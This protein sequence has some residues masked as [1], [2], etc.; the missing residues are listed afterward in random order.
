MI[1]ISRYIFNDSLGEQPTFVYDENGQITGYKT[2]VGADTVF[3]FSGTRE[4][5]EIYRWVSSDS[6]HNHQYTFTKD[7][8]HVLIAMGGG[9]NNAV[10]NSG[11]LVFNVLYDS[12]LD[13]TLR[14]AQYKNIKKD[15]VCS[16]TSYNG[17]HCYVLYE[18]K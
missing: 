9:I 4:L 14:M 6:G 3:P 17:T 8:D 16:I 13:C 2:K 5:K 7:Y 1:K 12:G 18:M 11:E 10:C 15:S